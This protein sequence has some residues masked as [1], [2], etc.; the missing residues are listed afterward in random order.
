MRRSV[1]GAYGKLRHVGKNVSHTVHTA[2]YVY[3]RLAPVLGKN[4]DLSHM[5]KRLATGYETYKDLEDAI[6]RGDKLVNEIAAHVRP[7]FN[8][9]F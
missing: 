1:A 2:A 5:N 8:P 3:S 7:A 9:S 4:F 6:G